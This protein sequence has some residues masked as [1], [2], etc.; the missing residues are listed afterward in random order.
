MWEGAPC[1]VK[2]WDRN[3]SVRSA[4]VTESWVGMKRAYFVRRSMITNMEVC[5][6]EDGSC[7]MRSIDKDSQGFGR[8]GSCFS[9]PYGLCL[10]SFDQAHLVQELTYCLTMAARPGQWNPWQ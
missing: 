3:S 1:L 8:M 6:L 10:A 2:T 7:L 4:D 5:P 9:R